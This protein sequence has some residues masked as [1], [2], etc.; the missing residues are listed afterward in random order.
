MENRS[1]HGEQEQTLRTVADRGN[2]NRHGEHV[3][4]GGTGTYMRNY[5]Q[6][7]HE[8]TWET[9]EEMGNRDEDRRKV[10]KDCMEVG[11]NRRY[12]EEDSRKVN[13]GC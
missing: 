10:V 12:V 3:R 8:Q 5:R 13:G 4:T 9:G 2:G 6:G 11:E 1:R 7:E